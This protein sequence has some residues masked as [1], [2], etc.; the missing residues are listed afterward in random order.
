MIDGSKEKKETS[1][2][3]EASNVLAHPGT[4]DIESSTSEMMNGK[5]LVVVRRRHRWLCGGV[6][7]GGAA[8]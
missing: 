8:V 3:R 1:P 4:R 2:N 5:P 7:R 6:R